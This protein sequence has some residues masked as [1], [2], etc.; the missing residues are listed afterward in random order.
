M[1]GHMPGGLGRIPGPKYRE[2]QS[3]GTRA[4]SPFTSAARIRRMKAGAM[5]RTV[6]AQESFKWGNMHS[7][8]GMHERLASFRTRPQD[9]TAHF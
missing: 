7:E 3:V 9:K 2:W 5:D 1:S 4:K 8:K 6:C